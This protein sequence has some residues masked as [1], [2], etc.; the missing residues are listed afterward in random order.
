MGKDKTNSIMWFRKVLVL[1][2]DLSYEANTI[3]CKILKGAAYLFIVLFY[4]YYKAFIVCSLVLYSIVM[5]I[6]TFYKI[7]IPTCI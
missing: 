2:I 7:Q 1:R 4:V 5:L 3:C 6:K